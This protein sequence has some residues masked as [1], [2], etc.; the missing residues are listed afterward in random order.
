MPWAAL[1]IR[2]QEAADLNLEEVQ[3]SSRDFFGRTA[4]GS[5]V[6]QP[7]TLRKVA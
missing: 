1:C 2:C 3:A 5:P 6:E 7:R 4:S